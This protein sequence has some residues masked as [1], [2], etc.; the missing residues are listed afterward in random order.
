MTNRAAAQL[1]ALALV[2]L[3]PS[4]AVGPVRAERPPEW[5]Q[6]LAP[7]RIAG[8]LYYVGTRDLASY[9]IATPAGHVLINS[10]LVE[11]AP[12]LEASVESLGFRLTDVRILLIS[13]AHFDHA[14][15]S[16][17]LVRLTRAKYMVM[18]ADVPLVESGGR[19]DFAYGG[20]STFHFPPARVDRVLH[21]GE[22][23][24]L[25]GTV[26]VAH[27]TGGHTPGC[28]TWTLDERENGR[29]YRVVIVGGVNVNSGYRLVDNAAYP[30]IANDFDRTFRV[31]KSLPCDI[32]LGAHGSYFDL[33]SKLERVASGSL[34]DSAGY[35]AFVADREQ[36]FRAEL[37]KQRAE[38]MKPRARP[39]K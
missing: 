13:H 29:T 25:G 28:T 31:L 11:N 38:R 7:F 17:T 24:S 39:L 1:L 34:V 33:A 6:P 16:D 2:L 15:A 35:R 9:L 32:F 12:L 5:T 14:A 30:Q 4:L 20:D 27:R 23:V 19:K 22:E 10:G 21:D 36:A 3:A 37:E 26:L 18:D 8:N